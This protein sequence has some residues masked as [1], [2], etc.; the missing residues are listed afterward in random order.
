ML[1]S[2][3]CLSLK[4]YIGLRQRLLIFSHTR[5]EFSVHFFGLKCVFGFLM[6]NGWL[7]VGVKTAMVQFFFL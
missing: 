7:V 5:K 3:L 4:L 6:D 1:Y 2:F